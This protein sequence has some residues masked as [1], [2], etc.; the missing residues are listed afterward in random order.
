MC[1]W[2]GC[3]FATVKIIDHFQLIERPL[4]EL[5]IEVES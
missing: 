4:S 1:L 3:Y 2:L 5:G